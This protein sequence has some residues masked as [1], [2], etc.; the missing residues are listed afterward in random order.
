MWLIE[1]DGGGSCADVWDGY[2][3]RV[4]VSWL[5]GVVRLAC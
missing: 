4:E 1:E 3:W 5:F 2:K